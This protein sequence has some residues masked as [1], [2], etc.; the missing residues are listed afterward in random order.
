MDHRE[1]LINQAQPAFDPE[2]SE[3]LAR[4]ECF[5]DIDPL[6]EDFLLVV[7]QKKKKM[8]TVKEEEADRNY[9]QEFEGTRRTEQADVDSPFK[10]V[11]APL[12]VPLENSVDGQR[13]S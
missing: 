2:R 12:Q 13:D 10:Q 3:V 5:D 7:P 1:S 8:P 9:S 6:A 11:D 4:E